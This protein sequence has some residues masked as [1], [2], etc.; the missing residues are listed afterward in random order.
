M[1]LF[2]DNS[3]VQSQCRLL[4]SDIGRLNVRSFLELVGLYVQ[5]FC[6]RY[7]YYA[8]AISDDCVTAPPTYLK[9][10]EPKTPCVKHFWQLFSDQF[11]SPRHEALKLYGS[12]CFKEPYKLSKNG[13]HNKYWSCRESVLKHG[14]YHYN[15]CVSVSSH[16]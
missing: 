4:Q 6:T 2:E 16:V 9:P 12:K 8:L 3:I 1:S 11:D 7:Q 14:K 15:V 13:R 5:S 10:C